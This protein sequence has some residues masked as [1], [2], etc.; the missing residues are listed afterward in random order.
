VKTVKFFWT[1]FWTFLLAQMA[2]YVIG[3]MQGIAYQFSTGALLGVAMTVFVI[4][5]ANV[6]PNEPVHHH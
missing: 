4:I 6:L 1:F 5:V 2:T 3:S